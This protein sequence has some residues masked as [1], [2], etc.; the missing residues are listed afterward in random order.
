VSRL[1]E[2]LRATAT[3]DAAY[4]AEDNRVERLV[5][6]IAADMAKLEPEMRDKLIAS[7]GHAIDRLCTVK[8]SL[9]HGIEYRTEVEHEARQTDALLSV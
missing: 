6:R 4:N 5:T 7:T 2:D 8:R 1:G 9:N 3:I